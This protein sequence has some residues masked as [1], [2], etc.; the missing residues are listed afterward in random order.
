MNDWERRRY[1]N[2]NLVEYLGGI[3]VGGKTEVMRD[4]NRFE[5]ISY[6]TK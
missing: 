1:L 3:G 4:S 6:L 2:W 5:Y